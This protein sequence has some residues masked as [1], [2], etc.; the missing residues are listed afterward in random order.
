MDS[1][2][3]LDG[4]FETK[5]E[6]AVKGQHSRDTIGVIQNGSEEGSD[7]NLSSDVEA[8]YDLPNINADIGDH[9]T[10]S[11]ESSAIR[12]LSEDDKDELS[13]K[14]VDSDY[15]NSSPT[16]KLINSPNLKD[17]SPIQSPPEVDRGIMSPQ[18]HVSSNVESPEATDVCQRS[19]NSGISSPLITDT[20]IKEGSIS[21]KSEDDDDGELSDSSND[22]GQSKIFP[23]FNEQNEQSINYDKNVDV[24][25]NSG[26]TKELFSENIKLSS[27]EHNASKKDDIQGHAE[28]LSDVSDLDSNDGHDSLDA[29]SDEDKKKIENKREEMLNVRKETAPVEEM[30]QLDFEAEEQQ[31]KEDRE[32]GE[33][34][35]KDDKSDDEGE[36]KGDDLEEGELTD[37]DENRPEE[38]EP[39]PVCRFYNRGQC[40]WGSSCRY[41]LFIFF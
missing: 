18:S 34:E 21:P 5:H 8:N 11:P 17:S 16:D 29:I 2:S 15:N 26:E 36:L 32:E 10:K 28:D 38:T 30:E 1:D 31:E 20:Q 9:V 22:V 41:L 4:D 6:I 3:S 33:C 25:S 12:S 24:P 14:S 19:P 27:D 13:L 7:D 37:E 35:G 23:A 40:T 39:R